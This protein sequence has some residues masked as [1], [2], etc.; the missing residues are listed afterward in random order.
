MADISI[1]KDH[2][3]EVSVLKERVEK[4][5]GDL[6]SKYGVR[7]KWDGNTIILSGTGIKKATLEI[8][9]NKISIEIALGLMAKMLK[10]KIEEEISSKLGS[11]LSV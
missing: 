1:S 6:Q 3:V 5:V 4:L 7:Y 11:V 2:A 9:D 10:G 8:T